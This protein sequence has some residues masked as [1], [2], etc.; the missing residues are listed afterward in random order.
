[1]Y[2]L[3]FPN[4][5]P[6]QGS[7]SFRAFHAAHFEKTKRDQWLRQILYPTHSQFGLPFMPHPHN[8]YAPSAYGPHPPPPGPAPPHGWPLTQQP[9]Y[10][11]QGFYHPMSYPTADHDDWYGDPAP[12][13][14][15]TP[16]S[17]DQDEEAEDDKYDYEDFEA[18]D[19]YD[20]EDF[21]ADDDDDE[22]VHFELTEEVIAMFAFSEARRQERALEAESNPAN[23]LIADAEPPAAALLRYRPRDTIAAS[24]DPVLASLEAVLDARYERSCADSEVVMWPVLPLRL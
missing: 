15:A 10:P 2:Y 22:N 3:P 16:H 8:P 7:L 11:R 23:D 14:E 13:D 21:E 1:S 19:E 12:E 20:Y 5:V 4:F 17:G 9:W 18:D 24:S 6:P